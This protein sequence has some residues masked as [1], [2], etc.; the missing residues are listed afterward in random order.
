[1]L[2]RGGGGR[3][4]LRKAEQIAIWRARGVNSGRRGWGV[5]QASGGGAAC[6]EMGGGATRNGLGPGPAGPVLQALGGPR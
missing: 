2:T 1:M 5:G 6:W 3:V 4:P